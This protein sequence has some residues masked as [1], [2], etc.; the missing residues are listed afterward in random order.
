MPE[1][2][3]GKKRRGVQGCSQTLIL[4]NHRLEE[5]HLE[6]HLSLGEDP[7]APGSLRCLGLLLLSRLTKAFKASDGSRN[8]AR[9]LLLLVFTVTVE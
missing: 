2:L 8:L 5:L 9:T 4:G 7:A 3:E 1:G 6:L